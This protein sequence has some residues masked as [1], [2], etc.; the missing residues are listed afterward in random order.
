ML[1]TRPRVRMQSTGKTPEFIN[2]IAE[3]LLADC[4]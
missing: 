2:A 4:C 3:T 1:K